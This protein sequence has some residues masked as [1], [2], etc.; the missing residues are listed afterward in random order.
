M[1]IFVINPKEKTD[2]LYPMKL[3]NRTLLM[4]LTLTV[5]T[6]KMM[7]ANNERVLWG[8]KATVDA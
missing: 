7:A 8:I 3:K 6:S 4:L 1:L 2:K 5:V